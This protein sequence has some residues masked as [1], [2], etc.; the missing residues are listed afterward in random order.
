MVLQL[1]KWHLYINMTH[2]ELKTKLNTTEHSFVGLE[3]HYPPISP[4]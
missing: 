3:A 2:V 1:K 4:N